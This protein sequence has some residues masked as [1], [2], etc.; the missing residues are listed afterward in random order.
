MSIFEYDKEKEMKLLRESYLEEGRVEGERQG[1]ITRDQEK[2]AEMLQRG[3][4][5][6]E[7]ADFCGYTLEQI[8]E[9]EKQSGEIN[10]NE[11][12]C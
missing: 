5:P 11:E 7:I 12:T 10:R 4:S 6:Q 9:V 8:Q 3:K 1:R 2:I